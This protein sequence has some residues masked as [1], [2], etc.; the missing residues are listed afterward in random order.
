MTLVEILKKFMEADEAIKVEVEKLLA[1]SR[2]QPESTVEQ[3]K[4]RKE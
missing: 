3:S 2:P 1:E 4:D